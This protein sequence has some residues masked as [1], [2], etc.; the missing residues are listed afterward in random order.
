MNELYKERLELLKNDKNFVLATIFDSQG[1]APRKTGARMIIKEDGSII[2]T[3]GGGKIEALVI[4]HGKELFDIKKSVLKE[5]K[6]QEAEHNG[7]GMAC[8]GDVRILMEY[9]SSADTSSIDLYTEVERNFEKKEKAFLVR[10]IFDD[11]NYINSIYKNGEIIFSTT[12]LQREEISKYSEKLRLREILLIKEDNVAVLI[13]PIYSMSNIY[14]FGAGH[15]SQKLADLVKKL[16][17][18]V[19]V[20]DDRAEFAN[21]ERFPT[22]DH[23]VIP[24]SFENC[25]QC[26]DIDKDSYIVILTRGHLFDLTVLQQAL[27]T[28]AY[29]IGMIGSRRKRDAVYEALLNSGFTMEDFNR[30]NNPIG[31]EIGAETPEEISVSIAAELI[32]VRRD[33]IQ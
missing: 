21:P 24:K 13:E 17:F 1:S 31:I 20:V 5:Y 22:T 26:V 18:N 30:V 2:G 9:V 6:L 10:K 28:E 33:R 8:G 32:K 27:R 3:I 16:D 19:T 7:I 4:E 29:Y 11:G 23:I 14:L 12:P 15:V 25:F